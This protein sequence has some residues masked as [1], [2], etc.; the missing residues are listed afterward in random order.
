MSPVQ[1]DLNQRL[2]RFMFDLQADDYE[3]DDA[4][5]ELAWCD[6]GV[7]DFWLTQAGAVVA[8]LELETCALSAALTRDEE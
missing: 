1:D 6:E 2:A 7:R 4:L 3:A 8:F 5:R